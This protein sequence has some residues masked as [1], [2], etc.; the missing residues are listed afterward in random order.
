M[1]KYSTEESDQFLKDVEEAAVWVLL[2]NIEQSEA[3]AEKKVGDLNSELNT[4]KA[5][6]QEF[7]ES[8]EVDSIHG[9]RRFPVY[10]GRYSAKWIVNHVTKTV[11]FI[12]LSDSK[13]PKQLRQVQ[14][15]E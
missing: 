8:G 3:L 14:F 5:R 2:T 1:L 11:T 12:T 4:L 13:Y 9:I 10:D 7:P 6:L 15:D